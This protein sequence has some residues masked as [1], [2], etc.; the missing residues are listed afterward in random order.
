MYVGFIISSS[1]GFVK[2]SESF[3]LCEFFIS[4]LVLFISL[5]IIVFQLTNYLTVLFNNSVKNTLYFNSIIIFIFSLLIL[6][7]SKISVV[8]GV[9]GI[10]FSIINIV[11]G[12]FYNEPVYKIEINNIEK[13]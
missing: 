5:I 12:L 2:L 7:L 3:N 11:Y 6:G 4:L 9:F 13:I 8:F 1:S 10:I